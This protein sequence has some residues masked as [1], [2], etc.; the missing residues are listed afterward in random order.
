MPR[1]PLEVA[2]ALA[3]LVLGGLACATTAHADSPCPDGVRCGTV[4]VPLDRTD[5]AA[6]TLDVAYAL[7]PRTD[8]SRPALGTIA[9]NPGGPGQ[10]TIASAGLYVGALAPLRERRDL[11][12]IDPRGTGRSG[13]LS[14]SSLAGRDPLGLDYADLLSACGRELGPRAALY[15]SAAVAD[16]IDA[17]RAALNIDKLDLWGD[18]YGTFLMPVYAARHPEHV[19]SM[20]LDGAYPIDFDVW[21]RDLVRGVR[22]AIRLVCARTQRCSGPRVLRQ[23]ERLAG[24]LRRHPVAFSAQGPNGRVALR[25]GERELAEVTYSDGDPEVYGRLPAAV[26][27]ALDR[28][29]APLKRLVV[30]SK[31]LHVG[32]DPAD[33]SVISF[34]G[35]A[36]T[37]CHDYPRAFSLADPPAARR[38]A[39]RRALAKVDPAEFKPFSP[40]AWLSTNIEPGPKC[41]DAPVDPTAGSPLQGLPLP[42]VPVLVQS[43]DL[44]TNTPVEAGRAA[45]AQFAHPIYGVVANAGHTPDLQPCGV[46]MAIDFI[47]HLTTNPDRCRHVGRPP[48]VAARPARHAAELGATAVRRAVAVARA[49]VEDARSVAASGVPGRADALRGGSY[50][51][52]ADRVRVVGA[53]VVTD[54]TADGTI[55]IDAHSTTARLRLHGPGLPRARLTVRSAGATTRVTGTVDGRR[56]G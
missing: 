23:I 41:L 50:V 9:P 47:E 34:A 18:S 36:A 54:A 27:A 22:R 52:S 55:R 35:Q 26:D 29:Y 3:V 46:A 15:G 33:P 38:A 11:L 39:Y 45:A 44:D 6:G 28:D 32:Y 7:V 4:T 31:L 5:P 8:T 40:D 51:V 12:L 19:R 20:V 42:D 13:A 1:S 25:L 53:R 43:G 14:C 21:G 10:S 49:T 2:R 37:T 16:D 17:V 56:V 24:R 48:T 30:A